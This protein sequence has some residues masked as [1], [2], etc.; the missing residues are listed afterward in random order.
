MAEYTTDADIALDPAALETVP[1]IES[2]MTSAGFHRGK[3]VGDWCVSREIGGVY[4]NVE[5]DLM[6]PE[7]VSGAGSRAACLAGHAKHVARKSARPRHSQGYLKSCGREHSDFRSAFR[8]QIGI[9]LVKQ[10]RST[11]CSCVVRSNSSV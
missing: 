8:F 2:A 7:V 1:E 6:V 10:R 9:R 5:V 11:H 3:R 4:A